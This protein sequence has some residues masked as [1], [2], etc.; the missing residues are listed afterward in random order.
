VWD[1]RTEEVEAGLR[2]QILRDES[3]ASFREIFSLLETDREFTSWYTSVLSGSAFESFFWEHPPISTQNYDAAAEFVLVDGPALAMLR[4]D[5]E[6]FRSQFKRQQE[7]E[8]A[9]FSNLGG[10]AVL[11]VPQPIGATTAY[12]HLAAFVRRAPPGQ[13]RRL[14]QQ[15]G[16]AVREN[17]STEPRWISTAGMG[18]PWLHIR[19]DSYPKYYRFGPY[20]A[21][22]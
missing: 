19:I 17:L 22:A 9:T 4:P 3:N 7:E 10:D 14:W 20:K 2:F 13:V 12:G 6:P 1:V 5:P 15:T 11:V 16:R 18:V 8:V 21:F